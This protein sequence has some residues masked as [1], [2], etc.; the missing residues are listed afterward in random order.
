MET[1][2]EVKELSPE[3][4]A[5]QELAVAARQHDIAVQAMRVLTNAR[6]VGP[7]AVQAELEAERRMAGTFLVLQKALA[8]RNSF[9]PKSCIAP[10]PAR[11]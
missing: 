3:E 10:R 2:T 6:A 7:G 1:I 11:R 4:V 8:T 5:Q 9:R